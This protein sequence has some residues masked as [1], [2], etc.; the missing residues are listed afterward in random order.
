MPGLELSVSDGSNGI[1]VLIAFEFET[2]IKNG[3]NFIEQFLNSAFEGTANRENSNTRCKYN[4][5]GL[6]EKLEEHRKDGRDSFIVMAH[7]EQDCGFCK[8]LDGGRISHIAKG[9]L[10]KKNVLGFQKLRTITLINSLKTWFNGE[11]FL[12]AFLEGSDCK[13]MKE[14]GRCGTQTN[15]KGENVDKASFIKRLGKKPKRRKTF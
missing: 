8:E 6:F 13:D 1:H 14:V 4:L 3:T 5:A 12:P 9:S 7:V 2:W 15:E 11:A 10:F